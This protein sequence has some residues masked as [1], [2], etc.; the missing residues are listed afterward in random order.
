MMT[1]RLLL[2]AMAA[3]TISA[4][5]A[6]PVAEERKAK[7]LAETYHVPEARISA[8][9]REGVGWKEISR[10]AITA[11]HAGKDAESMRNRRRAAGWDAMS[12]ELGVDQAAVAAE[13]RKITDD[14]ERVERES[15]LFDE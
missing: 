11:K 3:V 9:R 12:D 15:R 2:A 5:A 13:L 14:L 8:W 10:I 4:S 6:D 1:K 7:Y